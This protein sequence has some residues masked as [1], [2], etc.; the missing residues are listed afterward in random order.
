MFDFIRSVRIDRIG[1]LLAF[2]FL[3]GVPNFAHCQ[4]STN[5]NIPA[6]VLDNGGGTCGSDHHRL[7]FSIGQAM[8]DG[9]SQDS[10]RN[11]SPGFIASVAGL[12]ETD[13]GSESDDETES[14]DE[15]E[16]DESEKTDD[17]AD[18]D[19]ETAPGDGSGTVGGAS[20]GDGCFISSLF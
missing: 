18:T 17:G 8:G 16:T 14:G 13:D 20:F 4:S 5:Y 12:R 15:T 3:T 11:L 9:I 6:Q 19:D 2:C 1:L 10:R 7:T